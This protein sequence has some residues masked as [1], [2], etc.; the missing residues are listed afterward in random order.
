LQHIAKKQQSIKLPRPP[1]LTL[2]NLLPKNKRLPSWPRLPI[3][4]LSKTGT[5]PTTVSTK[6][7]TGTTGKAGKAGEALMPAVALAMATITT[8]EQCGVFKGATMHNLGGGCA[9]L[10]FRVVNDCIHKLLPAAIKYVSQEGVL[11]YD[12]KFMMVRE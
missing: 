8:E 9:V 11:K 4:L 6:S 1:T 10:V 12:K 3:P 2:C 5:K 7:K